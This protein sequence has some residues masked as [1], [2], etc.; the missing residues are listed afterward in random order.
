MPHPHPTPPLEG[1]Q[2]QLGALTALLRDHAPLWRPRPF[3]EAHPA[4]TRDLPALAA[5]LEGLSPEAIDALDADPAAAPHDAPAAWEALRRAAAQAAAVPEAPPAPRAALPD[6]LRARVPPRKW[7]QLE[8]FAAQVHPCPQ[9]TSLLDWCAGKGHLGRALAASLGLPV[10]HVERQRPLCAQG[11]ALDAE[12]GVCGGYHTADVLRGPPLPSPPPAAPL[13]V[14]LHACGVLTDTLL[15]LAVAQ[16]WPALFAAPCCYHM[17]GGA[18]AWRPLS[19]AGAASGLELDPRELRLAI[20][21][22]VIASPVERAA[23]RRQMAWRLAVDLLVREASGRDAYHTLGNLSA[24]TWHLPFDAFARQTADARGYP[25]PPRFDPAQALRR[26]EERAHRARALALVRG[27]F[28]R[29]LEV[30]LVLDRALLLAEAGRPV[31]VQTFCPTHLTPR[32]LMIASRLL[33]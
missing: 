14:A 26:G 20:Y 8:A 19:A 6:P 10:L 9:A 28:R 3:I 12:A 33:A 5:W 30:W 21:D 27:L 2:A 23:R 1:L 31:T 32:N 18:A 24:E 11:A 25:L 15:R 16:G 22:E 4:W 13:A 17:L 29:P 7:A